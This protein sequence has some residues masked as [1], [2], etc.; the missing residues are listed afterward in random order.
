VP[1]RTLVLALLAGALALNAQTTQGLISGRVLNSVTGRPVAGASVE[2]SAPA[3]SAAGTAKT[4]IGGYYFLPLLSAGTYSVRAAGEAY[5]A[6]ELQ[7]IELAVAGRVQLDFRLRPLSDVWEAGQYRSVFLP[8]T[9]TVVTFY[10][11]DVDSSRSGS[12]EAQKG[13]N[14]TLDTSQ[15]YVIDP[16]QIA[17]LPLLGRDVYTML[18]SL[19]GVAADSATGR[20]LG[21][22]VAGQRPSSSNF[23]L[24]GVE[25][26]NYLVTGPLAQVAPEAVQ[27]YRIST[28][29]Y[30]AEYGRTAGFIANAV[31]R[32]GSS[33]YHG[34]GY[35]YL[36]NDVLDAADFSDNLRGLGRR[37]EKQHQFGF[38]AGG[39][40]I[41]RG[42]L[43]NRLFFSSALEKLMSHSKQDATT[44]LLPSTNFIAALN[45]PPARIAR[46][47]LTQYPGPVVESRNLFAPYTAAPPVDVNRLTALERGDYAT[48][49]GRDHF[50]ARLAFSR[51]NQPDF[52]W[53]P[54][55]DFVSGLYDNT[56][57]IAGNW[58]RTWTPRLTSELKFSYSDDNLWWDRAHSEIPTLAAF[59]G[60]VLPGSPAAYAYRN[61]G[62]YS[63][64]IYSTVWTRNRHVITAGGGFLDRRTSGYLTAAR[65]SLY[66]FSGI[67]AF[68]F[69]QPQFLSTAV[70]RSIST[71][72]PPPFDRNWRSRQGHLFAQD[73]FRVT[74]RLTL[75]Y[76]LRWEYS[77]G[78]VNT[79]VAKD[80]LLS[81]G[82]GGNF[83]ARLAS[84]HLVLPGA[85]DQQMFAGS[86]NWAPRFGFTWDP[87]GKSKILLRGGFG[88]FYDRPF[89]NL[90]QN[91]RDN[92]V[93][94]PLLSITTAPFNY[95]QSPADVLKGFPSTPSDFPSITAVDPQLKNGYTQ[96]S[97]LGVQT[98]VHD[99]LSVEIGGTS[100]LARRLVTTDIV[101]RAFT[102]LVGDGRPNSVLPD[103]SWRSGQGIS[104]YYALNTLIRYRTRTLQ[105]Q[106]AYTWSHSI[107]N[108]SDPLIGDFFDLNFSSLKGGA[109]QLKSSF[110][111]Q[112]DS[113]ADRGNSAFDQRHNL[114][115]LGVWQSPA[116]RWWSRN[117][118]ASGLA[119]FRTGTPYTVLASSFDIPV[120]GGVI[121]NQRADLIG[122][123]PVL[124]NPAP[125][126]GGLYLLNPN[127][128][129]SPGAS[130]TG[131]TGRNAFRGPGLYNMDLSVA[132]SFAVPH[133]M[134]GTRFTLRADAFNFLNHANLGN[135]DNLVGSP[136]FGL[137][138]FGRQ[139]TASGF[140][141]SAPLN[142]TARQ[143]QILLRLEF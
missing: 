124:A 79:G 51:L 53:T 135:P 127:A 89:D 69:D 6:Q 115:L 66:L 17:N 10:G 1:I 43:R 68:G 95:L 12:F 94:V 26:D 88:L 137:A 140:P 73:S 134:E 39:P 23:L 97:F 129:A 67:L 99:N 25:N 16:V 78:P 42:A 126:P 100:A 130:S 19:P 36:K 83:T 80:L 122:P 128:F 28:N 58:Q 62:K 57:G 50:I 119:A 112:Y 108:Q 96:T 117:W 14:G 106:G 27:E 101:N 8:G 29:N 110:A 82:P 132:R 87:L 81:L 7:E 102:T 72:T 30:S 125:A 45:L 59:D 92:R 143:F 103:V 98:A 118:I 133:L 75:N 71:P 47:L 138:T 9:K 123:A 31:T 20:G 54:Y 46:Q 141:A 56:T 2:Y 64:A 142:E 52:I 40:V 86:S 41:P 21:I 15:S 111:R 93:S 77:G 91:V 109:T 84:G 105:L 4:D 139:G 65:D 113:G 76:G 48:K 116:R 61:H 32:A 63:E 5:Q 3:L 136:T 131:N 44:F 24:D 121:E 37:P 90:W 38:Q 33:A 74:S 11:P 13:Q 34:I 35:E 104:N 120:S 22:S 55:P 107:D 70:D 60:V 49:S 114:F 18:V 85:G